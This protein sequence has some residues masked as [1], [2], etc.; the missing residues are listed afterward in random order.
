VKVPLSA[1]KQ[2]V[3][4][5]W[6]ATT[7][8]RRLTMAGLEVE[9]VEPA[10]PPFSG[11]VVAKI[12][13]AEAHPQAEKLQVCT[14]VTS[15]AP[16]AASVQIVCGASNARAGLV[17]AL[18]IVGAE[19]PGDAGAKVTIKAAR[20]RGVESQGMIVAASL[21]GGPPVLAGFLEDVPLGAR[22]K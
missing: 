11:V 14:V 20:L 9:S 1:L 19:L 2:W 7:L 18:A 16:G 13:T 10:A 21:E 22:L 12:I 3:D 5:P 8:A 15:A 6:D 17:S 4:V